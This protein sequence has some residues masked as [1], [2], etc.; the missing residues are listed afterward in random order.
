M[1]PREMDKTTSEKTTILGALRYATSPAQLEYIL[2]LGR[3]I[4]RKPSVQVVYGT[5]RNEAL[6]MQLKAFFRNVFM[7][8]ER[9]ARA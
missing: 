9:N 3:F 2:N 4:A 6:H 7:Q 8:T 5:A 1:S